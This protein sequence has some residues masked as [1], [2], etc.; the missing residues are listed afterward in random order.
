MWEF[1]YKIKSIKNLQSLTCHKCWDDSDEVDN[2]DDDGGDHML[3]VLVCHQVIITT[4][5]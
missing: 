2:G 4:S 1:H 3:V 5:F